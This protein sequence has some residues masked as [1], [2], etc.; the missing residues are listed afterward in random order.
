MNNVF[1][2]VNYKIYAFLLRICKIVKITF[3]TLKM[4]GK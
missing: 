3:N 1:W 4:Y 2:L